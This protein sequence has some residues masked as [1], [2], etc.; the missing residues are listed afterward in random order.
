MGVRGLAVGGIFAAAVA[1]VLVAALHVVPPSARVNPMRRTISEYGLLETA[2]VFNTALLVLAA[3]SAAV[4]ASLV[5]RRVVRLASVGGAA[6]LLWTASLPAIVLFPKHN[7]AVGPSMSGTVHRAVALIGFLSLPAAALAVGWAWRAH[8][9]W[10]THAYRTMILGWCSLLC[11][12]PL[13]YAILSQPITGVRWWR[14]VPLGAVERLLAASE[15]VIVLALG[16]WAARSQ[17]PD[18]PV[19]ILAAT[20]LDS[21]SGSA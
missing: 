6:L 16:W 3:G 12:S 15:V 17:E 18:E 1:A 19:G 2:W 21:R 5:V 10:R 20:P 13:A 11:F 8:D 4:L 7:W 14:A 9:R